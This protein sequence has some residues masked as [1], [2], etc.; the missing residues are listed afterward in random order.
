MEYRG[1]TQLGTPPNTGR[2]MTFTTPL[3][4]PK[5]KDALS[6]GRNVGTSL[7]TTSVEPPASQGQAIITWSLWRFEMIIA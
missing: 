3:L 4:L 2:Q 6:N 7:P 1:K 5:E